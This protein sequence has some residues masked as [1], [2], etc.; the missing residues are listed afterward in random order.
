MTQKRSCQ[1]PLR[2]SQKKSGPCGIRSRPT[3]SERSSC[4][5]SRPLDADFVAALIEAGANKQGVAD[6]LKFARIQRIPA[7]NSGYA[8]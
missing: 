1:T 6:A 8:R 2:S 3:L 5:D 4:V 7:G